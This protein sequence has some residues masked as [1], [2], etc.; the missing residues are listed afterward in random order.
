MKIL[1]L[2]EKPI[3]H[4][5]PLM[6]SK[7]SAGF[8]SPAADYI[9]SRIDLNKEFIRHPAATFLLRAGGD[10]MIGECIKPN[11][12]L[13]VDRMI[14]TTCGDVVIARLGEDLCVKQLFID[15]E[16]KVF[17][18]PSNDNYKAVEITEDM[19]FEICGKVMFS[20]NK[21]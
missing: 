3:E 6:M 1:E 9:E 5:L 8:P 13:I 4:L 10:S 12:V 7:V 19:D 2:V 20:I 14:E 21:H 15:D 18:M 11:A 17:L 16:G